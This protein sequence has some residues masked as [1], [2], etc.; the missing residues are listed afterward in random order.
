MCVSAVNL[1]ASINAVNFLLTLLVAPSILKS[2]TESRDAVNF[3]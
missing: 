3:S 1:T 2:L